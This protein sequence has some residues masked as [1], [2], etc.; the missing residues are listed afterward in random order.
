LDLSEAFDTVDHSILLS[1]LA[2][3]FSIDS[4]AF[5]WFK[6]YLSDCTQT[7]VYAGVQSSNFPVECSIPQGSV[8]GPCCFISYTEDVIDLLESHAVQ[9]HLYADD[10]Q[11]HDNCRPDDTDALR[12]RLSYCACEIISW[13]TSRRLQLNATKTEATWV[14][15][16]SNLAKLMIRDCSIQIGESTIQPSTVVR[17][18]GV[19]LDR[20]LSMKPHIVKVA[21]SCYYH[22]RRFRQIR[23]R[24]GGEVA[25]RLVLALIMSRIDYCNSVL[26]G[27]PQSTSHH[28]NGCRT[29][30]LD[31]SS[32]SAHACMSPP[33][34][35]RC[36]G[37]QCAGESSSS[38]AV[39]CTPSFTGGVR[40]TYP[41]S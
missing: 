39:L 4:T 15:S 35:F 3:Q 9:S 29:P 22:L 25:T 1:V 17:D 21:A 19:Y 36:T 7:F 27:L 34:F 20:E 13:C 33:V 24:V 11:F 37:C 14:G 18:L 31:W 12:N 23:R 41:T 2:D 16:K 32:S 40:T 10:T 26:A 30:L 6:S 28:Y 8:L 5:S 38:C